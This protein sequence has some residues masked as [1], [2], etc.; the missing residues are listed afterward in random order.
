MGIRQ[1]IE[2][3]MLI[4]ITKSVVPDEFSEVIK[5]LKNALAAG[6]AYSVS[7]D[8]LAGLKGRGGEGKGQGG[9]DGKGKE[10]E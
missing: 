4:Y 5:W 6:A 7:P 3:I 1:F 8:S 2:H 10:R 9:G